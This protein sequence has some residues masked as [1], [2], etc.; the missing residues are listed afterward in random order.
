[1]SRTRRRMSRLPPGLNL[2][3]LLDMVSLLIQ[4][5]LI[6]VQFD[7]YA[8]VG[9]RVA[10][11]SAAEEQAPPDDKALAFE[12]ALTDD[13]I[14]ARWRET[15]GA[16]ERKLPCRGACDDVTAWDATGLERLGEELKT[17][18]P[19]EQR[20]VVRPAPSVGFDVIVAAMDALRGPAGGGPAKFG[21]VIL[22]DGTP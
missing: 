1:M 6:N 7:T 9:S 16:Q 18:F 2:I 13:G 11:P 21:D 20:V 15:T 8:E 10:G 4:L 12:V 3:P 19:T 5:M 22:A 17:R 14:V